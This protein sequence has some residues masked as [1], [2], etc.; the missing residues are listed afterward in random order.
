MV[1]PLLRLFSHADHEDAVDGHGRIVGCIAHLGIRWTND[2]A[3]GHL[4]RAIFTCIA[5]DIAVFGYLL[6]TD[7]EGVGG[8]IEGVAIRCV[9]DRFHLV[10]C[11]GAAEGHVL[12]VVLCEKLAHLYNALEAG[13]E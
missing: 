10:I 4:A 13:M 11:R 6:A 5:H 1:L 3:K 7:V 2:A 8:M 9:A 12:G